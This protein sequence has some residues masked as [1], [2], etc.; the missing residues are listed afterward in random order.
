MSKIAVI[1]A[2][3]SG[4]GAA[5]HLQKKGHCVTVF[6]QSNSVGGRMHT[7]RKA[8][9]VWDNGAQ[10]MVDSYRYMK[11][12]MKELGMSEDVTYVNPIQAM[13]IGNQQIYRFQSGNPFSFFRHPKL[14]ARAKIAAVKVLYNAYK[15]RNEIDFHDSSRLCSL[16]DGRD[17]SWWRSEATDAL[18][19]WVLSVPTSTLFFWNEQDTSWH[20]P[21][22]S[23][24]DARSTWSIYT[25][26][27]GMG[28]VP[29]ALSRLVSVQL[30]ASVTAVES[31]DISSIRV[32]IEGKEAHTCEYF[33]RAIISVPAPAALRM[34]ANPELEL[35]KERTDFLKNTRYTT[36]VTTIIGYEKAP[37]QQAYGFAV[38]SVLNSDLAAIGWDHLKGPNRAPSGQGIAVAMPTHSYSQAN[39]SKADQEIENDVKRMVGQF[40]PIQDTRL[41]FTHIQRW[42]HAMPIQY[43]GWARSRDKALK[44][45]RPENPKLFVCGDYWAGPTTEHALYSGYQ[46]AEEVLDSF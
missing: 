11:E 30:G 10:F 8:G 25:P 31:T 42:R 17:L 13:A 39:W 6:E 35:G 16:D 3:I 5:Y 28:R 33:D 36:N 24:R 38:P 23:L 4:L 14:N 32:S 22:L 41:M 40:Y 44:A 18:V 19:D 2:G 34:I 15:Y 29:E 27:G 37:E 9:Y 20:A 1:G 21:L 26:N 12:L 46:A 7:S 43:P 45:I